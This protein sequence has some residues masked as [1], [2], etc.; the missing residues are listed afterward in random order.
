MPS[1]EERLAAL[2]LKYAQLLLKYTE[3]EMQ[4][5]ETHR[6]TRVLFA[7]HFG[8]V[9]ELNKMPQRRQ[10]S[11]SKTDAFF[12]KARERRQMLLDGDW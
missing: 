11:Y 9:D 4:V 12:H 3:L 6:R 1:S 8:L 7:K 5:K 10:L 2:E